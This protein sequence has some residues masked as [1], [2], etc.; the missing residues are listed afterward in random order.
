MNQPVFVL[1]TP[2]LRAA[3][4]VTVA[5]GVALTASPGD[6]IAVEGPNGSGKTT[7]LTAAAGLLPGGSA[8]VRPA[9]VSYSPER[10][11]LLPRISVLRWLVDLARTA[12]LSRRESVVQAGEVLRRLGLEAASSRPL[13]LAGQA[14][15]KEPRGRR[16]A[17][18]RRLFFQRA[19]T[20]HEMAGLRARY[21]VIRI[22][23]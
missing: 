15:R 3:R 10:A 4:G 1:G 14:G 11:A 2:R 19:P 5:T 9:S 23:R 12:G 18:F 7:L 13:R 16:G 20:F 17:G 6:V 8:T 21:V 22:V